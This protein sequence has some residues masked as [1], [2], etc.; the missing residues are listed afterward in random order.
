LG[1]SHATLA[2]AELG[3]VYGMRS[4]T[5]AAWQA[6]RNR[7]LNASVLASAALVVAA[8]YL[9]GVRSAFAAVPLDP[10]AAA[11]VLAL[12]L[13]PLAAVELYKA[14]RRSQ[15]FND[16]PPGQQLISPREASLSRAAR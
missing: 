7:W 3:L 14:W 15:T 9:P 12:S 6:P 13:V 10:A 4:T 5:A 1:A 11:T 8:V 16:S 2:L